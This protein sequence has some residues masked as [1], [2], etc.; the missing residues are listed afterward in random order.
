MRRLVRWGCVAVL[1]VAGCGPR[2]GDPRPAP[3]VAVS[4][5]NRN[6]SDVDVFV[7][8][9]GSVV[10]LG[11]VVSGATRG[12]VVRNLPRAPVQTLRFQVHRI[13][14][15]G[16]FALPAVAVSPGESVALTVEDLLTSSVVAVCND[17]DAAPGSKPLP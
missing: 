12:L 6:R 15:E 11:T 9:G 16:D 13:G 3:P 5:T 1:A 17:P 2:P 7:T 10:R 8:R 14:A 4:V